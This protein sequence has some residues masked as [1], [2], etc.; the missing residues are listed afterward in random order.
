MI[1][2][3]F[4]KI[5]KQGGSN[6]DQEQI[7]EDSDVVKTLDFNYLLSMPLLNLT[8]EKKEEILKQQRQKL[9]ELKDI[10]NKTVEQLWLDDLTLFKEEYDKAEL[11]E[12]EEFE[13][14]FVKNIEKVSGASGKKKMSLGAQLKFEYLPSPDGERI[15]PKIDAQTIAKVE[16]EAQQ[17]VLNKVKKDESLKGLNIVDIITSN[18]KLVDPE[19]IQQINDLT[20]GNVNKQKNK[21]AAGTNKQAKATGS[22]EN[23]EP[24]EYNDDPLNEL[25]IIDI[26]DN[27]KKTT[28]KTTPSKK[29]G[30]DKKP[31]TN[32]TSNGGK[33]KPEKI[34][35]DSDSEESFDDTE[36][37]KLDDEFT[38]VRHLSSG[39]AKKPVKYNVDLDN[40]ESELEETFDKSNIQNSDHS[41]GDDL[42]DETPKKELKTNSKVTK[43]KEKKPKTTKNNFDLGGSDNSSNNE[44][45][46]EGSGSDFELSNTKKKTNKKLN[47]DPDSSNATKKK[48]APKKEPKAKPPKKEASIEADSDTD[49]SVKK[50][51]AK[52]KAQPP[53]KETKPK[54]ATKK[55]A[56]KKNVYNSE[57]DGDMDDSFNDDYNDSDFD[58]GSAK[59]AKKA[60]S[61]FNKPK[62][63]SK[64]T[65]AA[66]KRK[67]TGSES[68]SSEKSIKKTK[69]MLVN[70]EDDFSLDE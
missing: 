53:K 64:K 6:N 25:P 55:P 34:T 3:N 35:V 26:I 21:S 60:P 36:F 70:D 51:P 37:S 10:Q 39:R 56:K 42:V 47:N 44:H 54:E 33:K 67:V 19:L 41:L 49:K 13:M 11:K 40:S 31:T 52:K 23:G 30:G 58:V 66:P 50:A 46:D 29:G 17:K 48:A 38:S 16:K 61:G 28:K 20:S 32:G 59:K 4:K 2:F 8:W 45:D 14:S 18:D 57:S 12:K 1:N 27:E 63:G 24:L 7:A 65:T 69:P 43:A 15:E 9:D 62:A 22:S 68:D 5:N